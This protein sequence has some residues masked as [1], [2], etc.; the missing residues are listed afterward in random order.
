MALG[1]RSMAEFS[2]CARSMAEFSDRESRKSIQNSVPEDKI[3]LIPI[4]CA[5]S[6]LRPR[7]Q[8]T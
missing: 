8:Q 5:A 7:H 2:E 6:R 3:L 4:L 1:V